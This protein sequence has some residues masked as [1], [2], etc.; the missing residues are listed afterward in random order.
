MDRVFTKYYSGKYDW[1]KA[2]NWSS[3]AVRL[4][5][6]VA[7]LVLSAQGYIKHLL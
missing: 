3:S 2:F 4:A 6:V 5:L 1:K 7:A